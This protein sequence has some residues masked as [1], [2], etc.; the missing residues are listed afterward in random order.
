LFG[1]ELDVLEGKRRVQF[2]EILV[3]EQLGDEGGGLEVAALDH[4]HQFDYVG[5]VQSFEEVVLSLDLRGLDR[6]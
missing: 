3:G 6:Q 4:I 5:V 2:S 1:I